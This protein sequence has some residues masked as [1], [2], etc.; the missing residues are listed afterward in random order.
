MVELRGR[1]VFVPVK[2]VPED[3]DGGMLATDPSGGA[4]RRNRVDLAGRPAG[5]DP[6]Q[7]KAPARTWTRP[8]RSWRLPDAARAAGRRGADVRRTVPLP[9]PA[10]QRPAGAVTC[11]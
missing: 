10:W 3:R 1:I 6:H 7:S 4:H 9:D 8:G 2:G 5:P 11:Y